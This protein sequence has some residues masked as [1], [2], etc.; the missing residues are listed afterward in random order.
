MPRFTPTC[1]HRA[2]PEGLL[3]FTQFNSGLPDGGGTSW[4][5]A[6]A[7]RVLVARDGESAGESTSSSGSTSAGPLPGGSPPDVET[8]SGEMQEHS[9]RKTNRCTGSCLAGSCSPS[10]A[11]RRHGFTLIELLVVIA[12]I[13]VLI[14]LL[15][16]A[17]QAAREAARRIQCTN[18]LKQLGLGLHN[19]ESSWTCLPAAAQ[20]GFAEIYLNFTGYNQ[21]LPYLEQSNA[22]NA[23]NFAVSQS[24]G[25]YH[26]FGWSDPSNTTTFQ[27]QSA[28]FLCPSES[29]HRGGGK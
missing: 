13:A 8:R 1:N 12:I 15:L 29:R 25:P 18:N 28:I 9:T 7:G 2:G 24:Y 4:I 22:F 11:A 23:T 16:P 6:A 19:Y 21:V 5:P 26:Y 10:C 14:A 20:G 17:V 27:F 3:A